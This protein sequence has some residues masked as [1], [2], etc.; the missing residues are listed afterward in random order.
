M[1]DLLALLY[2]RAEHRY[3]L[4]TGSWLLAVLKI[5]LIIKKL[6]G[7]FPVPVVLVGPTPTPF[8]YGPCL[9]VTDLKGEWCRYGTDSPIGCRMGEGL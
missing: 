5:L 4:H 9:Q 6:S 7:I 2:Y 3:C 8:N 1:S